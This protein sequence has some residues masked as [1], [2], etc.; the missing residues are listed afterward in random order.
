MRETA[1]RPQFSLAIISVTFDLDIG[2][3]DYIGILYH[4]EHTPE[5]WH[6][7]PGTPCIIIVPVIMIFCIN[8]N[9]ILQAYVAIDSTWVRQEINGQNFV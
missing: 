9:N 8:W 1:S 5:V 4:K 6:I 3:L 7:P 2:V